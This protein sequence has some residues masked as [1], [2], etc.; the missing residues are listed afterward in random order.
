MPFRFRVEKVWRDR[1]RRGYHA[2]GLLE[3]GSIVPP[4][5]ARVVGT[6]GGTVRIASTALG[7]PLPAGRLTFIAGP[8]TLDPLALEG[9]LLAEW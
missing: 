6:P 5:T 2:I 9:C 1:Q 3:E 4:L 7:G 8:S